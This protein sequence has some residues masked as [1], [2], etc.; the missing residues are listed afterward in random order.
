MLTP[1]GKIAPKTRTG[2]LLLVRSA[3]GKKKTGAAL[4]ELK[5]QLKQQFKNFMIHFGALA[6]CC[7]FIGTK[8]WHGASHV[9][10]C[11]RVRVTCLIPPLRRNNMSERTLNLIKDNEYRWV[12]LRFTDTSGKEQHVTIPARW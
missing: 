4:Y 11:T 9:H 5:A 12:D 8:S 6:R 1:E 2:A 7:S 3:W 10:Q